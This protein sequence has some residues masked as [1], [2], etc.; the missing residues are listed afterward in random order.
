MKKINLSMLVLLF[1][2]GSFSVAAAAP[3]TWTDV[4]DWTPDQKVGAWESV[5][6]THDV[7]DGEDGFSGLLMG[8]GGDDIIYDYSLTISLYDDTKDWWCDFEAA[9]VDQP[10]IIGDGFYD[11]NY[12][13]DTYGWSLAGLISLNLAGTL[14]VTVTSLAGDF[15]LDSSVLKAHGDNSVG[16]A[17]V[18]EPATIILFGSGLLGLAGA[19]RKKYINR[20]NS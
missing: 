4:I 16:G 18:P 20:S 1:V 12:K 6:Y 8:E 10:G 7:T 2:A 13:N 5:S 17:P 3:Y 11:F 19:G 15:F 9:W 14:D